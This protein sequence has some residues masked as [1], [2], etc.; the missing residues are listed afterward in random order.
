MPTMNS[1]ISTSPRVE[2]IDGQLNDNVLLATYAQICVRK[3][4]R[5]H[6]NPDSTQDRAGMVRRLETNRRPSVKKVAPATRATIHSR[7][8]VCK[9]RRKDQLKIMRTLRLRVVRSCNPR[10]VRG[11]PSILCTFPDRRCDLPPTPRAQVIDFCSATA[12]FRG[13]F[14]CSS[15]PANRAGDRT[16]GRMTYGTTD[17]R[18]RAI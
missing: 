1:N 5:H 12:I 9:V 13:S 6:S 4:N 11:Q 10:N 8:W 17:V 18:R 7:P 2:R 14:F 16:N 3:M 15:M